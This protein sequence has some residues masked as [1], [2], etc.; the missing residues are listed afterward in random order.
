MVSPG[1]MLR[2]MSESA[3]SSRDVYLKP[4]PRYS[5]LPWH[6]S[7]VRPVDSCSFSVSISS[8]T[9][10]PA[11]MPVCRISFTRVS[12]LAGVKIQTIATMKATNSPALSPDA[13]TGLAA[14]ASTTTSTKP[15]SIWMTGV[16][17]ALVV[18]FL[19]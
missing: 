10:S 14:T 18:T 5:I 2:L 15:T 19:R 1:A 13:I 4:T 12:F 9:L 16:L 8:N 6:F 3:R 17:A 11:A 7:S